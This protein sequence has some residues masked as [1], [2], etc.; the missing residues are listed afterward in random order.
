VKSRLFSSAM[1]MLFAA[2]I[3]GSVGT[4]HLVR[5]TN[6]QHLVTA[7]VQ[8]RPGLRKRPARTDAPPQDGSACH[9]GRR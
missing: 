7:S 9:T 6:H 8:Q 3:V 4:K 2:G 5:G 1:W